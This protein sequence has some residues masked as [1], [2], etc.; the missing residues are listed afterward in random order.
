MQAT[1]LPSNERFRG[2]AYGIRERHNEKGKSMK[3]AAL[4]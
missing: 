3:G 1:S 4:S 2:S